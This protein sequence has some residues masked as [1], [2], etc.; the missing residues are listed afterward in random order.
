[1]SST[2]A[3]NI[4]HERAVGLDIEKVRADFPIL[5]R[6]VHGKPLVYL[7]TAATA[8]RPLVVIEAIDQF[9]RKHNANVHRGVHQLSQE[10][11]GI[12]EDAR[13]ALKCHIN[14]ASERE[15][16]FTRGTTESINLV[17]QSYLRPILRAGDQ[18]LIS[19]M[20]HHSNIVPWQMLCEQTGAELVV[21]PINQQGELLL[22]ELQSLLNE[23]V[24][25]LA[26][27]HTSNA[28][29][30]INPVKKICA[31]A[32]A[33]GKP[34]LID[35]A[36]AMAHSAVDV[37]DLG[38]DFFCLS[39]HKMYG[40]T[41]I[42]A[43]WAKEALLEAMPPWQGGGEMIRTVTFEKTEYNELPAKF[44]AGTPNIAGAAGLGAAVKYLQALGMENI[45]AHELDV[46]RYATEKMS[47]V[48]GLRIIG[49]AANKASVLSF[50]LE[51][52]HPHDL[53]TIID[54]YGVAVRTGHHCTM[55]LMQ[56]FGLPATARAS[57]GMYNTK[58]EIDVLLDSIQRARE[59]LS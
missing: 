24:K 45:A 56:F 50:T 36:Q 9:Y 12:Y 35:G 47:A 8:Q 43:L 49:T 23:R 40:P 42:G 32:R 46:L 20:E 18:I 13:T 51:G 39:A 30:T 4:Q 3:K 38:C 14:A 10:A 37:Q 26:L 55:P 57:L 29:G 31:M 59:M 2:L 7:D 33:Y 19:C 41:G 21:A 11:T 52:V 28:L 25:L 54:H 44:E 48:E 1:M 16:I 5:T 17:A 58:A 53:G 34:V 6:E 27:V 22:D 15:V